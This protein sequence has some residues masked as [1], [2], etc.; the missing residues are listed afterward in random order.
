MTEKGYISDLYRQLQEVM[1]K[2]DNLSLQVKNIKKEHCEEINILNNKIKKLKIKNKKLNNENGKLR[3]QLN[4]NSN[5]RCYIY[6]IV[7]LL[8][9]IIL[10]NENAF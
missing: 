2:C 3:K 1:N 4:N 5:N 6:I 9:I 8:Y 7:S 10:N